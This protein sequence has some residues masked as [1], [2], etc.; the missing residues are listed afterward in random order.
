MSGIVWSL[1]TGSSC[2][3]NANVWLPAAGAVVVA[4]VVCW[5]PYHARRLMFCYV[6]HWSQ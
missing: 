6:S 1:K 3:A 2:V 5:L 4:F